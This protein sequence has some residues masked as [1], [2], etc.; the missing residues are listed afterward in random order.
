MKK[1]FI[2][3]VVFTLLLAGRAG[4]TNL[5]GQIVHNVSGGYTPAPGT[6]VDLVTW[7]GTAWTSYSYAVTG[8]DGYYY[9]MNFPPGLKFLLL[10]GGHYY[11][12]QPLVIA[13]LPG[14]SYQDMPV[15]SF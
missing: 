3:I 2:S 1:V 12:L 15:I 4:A 14:N 9:F 11:P 10:V 6:R 8:T 13:T 5:R 7:N